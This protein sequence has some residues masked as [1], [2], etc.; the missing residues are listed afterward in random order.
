[1]ADA[2]L[3]A[4]EEYYGAPDAEEAGGDEPPL[5]DEEEGEEDGE[6]GGAAIGTAA[7][8][9]AAGHKRSAQQIAKGKGKASAKAVRTAQQVPLQDE[10][11]SGGDDSDHGAPG[12]AVRV[13]ALLPH[14]MPH[15]Q[16]AH[17][18]SHPLPF[19]PTASRR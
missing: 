15:S 7:G 10:D 4:L 1:M 13:T 9:A 11:D 12:P 2:V 3:E 19:S 17:A 6:P 16:A 14:A 5:E 18:P 8:N